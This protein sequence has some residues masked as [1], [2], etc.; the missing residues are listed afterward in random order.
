MVEATNN[1][2]DVKLSIDL[3]AQRKSPI[4]KRV[5]ASDF[6]TLTT[7]AQALSAKHGVDA[8]NC[9]LRY[10]DGESWVIVED[11]DDLKLAFAIAMSDTKK[12][13]FTVKPAGQPAPK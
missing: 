6:A 11:D 8:G 3:A 13:T 1:R 7:Q 10:Y 12:L 5:A 4:V 2:L 9:P